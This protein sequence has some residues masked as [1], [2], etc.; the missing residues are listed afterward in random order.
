MDALRNER[1]GVPLFAFRTQPWARSFVTP[2]WLHAGWSPVDDSVSIWRLDEVSGMRYD[3]RGAFHLTDNGAVD[4]VAGKWNLAADILGNSLIAAPASGMDMGA[5]GNGATWAVWFRK[6][7]LPVNDGAWIFSSNA[8]LPAFNI[9]VTL[10]GFVEAQVRGSNG[11]VM[12]AGASSYGSVC[13]DVWHHA[14]V[15]FNPVTR[16]ISF[17]LDGFVRGGS[18]SIAVPTLKGGLGLNVGGGVNA[19][20]FQGQIDGPAMW[21][22]CLSGLDVAALYADG[23]AYAATGTPRSFVTPAWSRAWRT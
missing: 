19:E 3:S 14:V 15:T 22:R 2:P 18:A 6:S 21:D 5:I 12:V 10:P 1:P 8:F 7:S 23:A 4:S 16:S 11:A 20:F 9:Y 17:Y 13:D